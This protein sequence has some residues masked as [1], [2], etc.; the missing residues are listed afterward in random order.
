MR[1]PKK[2]A[3]FLATALMPIC[4]G[5]AF[6]QDSAS[7]EGAQQSRDTSAEDDFHVDEPIV[8]TAPYVK[9]LDILAGTSALAGE[10]LAEKTEGQIGDMLTSIPGVSASSFSPGASRP[11]LRGFQGNRVA[12][13]TDGIGNIDASNTSADHA[14]T[15]DALTAERIEVLRGPAVLLFG[16]SAVGG[17][18]NVID[19]R[20]PRNVPDEP[21]H[22]DALGG[23]ASA[24]DEWSGG[25]SADFRLADRLVAHI[26]GSYRESD[27]MRIG[28]YLL[29]PQLRTDTLALAAEEA[30]EGHQDEAD[31][32]TGIA[33]IRGRLPNSATRT[34][35]LGTGLAF[36]DEGGNLG[37][38]F[39]VY[40]TSYGIPSRPG[41]GH[42]HEG[43]EEEGPVSIGLRQ[44]R[45]D[46]RGEVE[47][48][49]GLF[50]TLRLRAGYADYEHTEFEGDEVG[51]RF[52]SKAIEARAELV[53]S[54][55]GGWR[56]ANGIQYQTRDFSAIGEEAFVPP[57][58]SDKLGL[59]TL[60]EFTLGNVGLEASL[61][62]DHAGIR[63]TSIGYDR[64]FNDISAALGL[65]YTAGPAK[66]G[67]NLS[68]T[69]RAPSVEELLSDGPHIATQSYEM[70][71]P[72]LESE[73]SWNGEVYARVDGK[74]VAASL[75]FYG[76]DFDNFIYE[77][78]TG[79]EE[80]GLPVFLYTQKKARI[81]GFEAEANAQLATIGGMHVVLDGVADYTHAEIEGVGPAPRIPPLRLL[82][83]LELKGSAVDLR[84][85]VEWTDKQDR[86]GAFETPTAGFTLVNASAT[87]RPFGDRNISLIVAANNIF[88]VEAR[89]AA[90]FTKDF[91]PLTGRD[92]RVSA[93]LSF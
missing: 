9:Q 56:G 47:L 43:G 53:Q 12:V 48:G 38:S 74:R 17:A 77:N 33:N 21:V 75:T 24:A 16:G 14:V 35:S 91:A 22:I 84:G 37:A 20:I 40:D 5:S 51:T 72:A 42:A 63:A 30:D 76:N 58:L 7:Q 13:L 45:A 55:R 34:W 93:R 88:D 19:K 18:V 71:N 87:F 81:W 60:Q 3:L 68:R 83:G 23:Y 15:I 54:E 85:E 65:S 39:N 67:V 32:L 27:D 50:E 26:D 28:G 2:T 29:S 64:S 46:L 6:A 66:F 52:L 36:I 31:E 89:R 70:G 4:A 78:A 92:I 25:A 80:D 11:I 69:A 73:K 82:G 59:F 44:Y 1:F 86:T 90:S 8:V 57:S 62:Y 79:A 10:A 41:A 61:R 49:E